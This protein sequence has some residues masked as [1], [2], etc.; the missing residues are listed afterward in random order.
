[1]RW[2]TV[3][4]LRVLL[5]LF[6]AA[7]AYAVTARPQLAIPHVAKGPAIDGTLTDEA[8]KSA[9]QIPLAWDL[10]HKAAPTQA[11]DVYVLSDDQALYVA[12][13]AK[14]T[15]EIV[16][17]QHT[18]DVGFD[19]DDEV[20]VDLWPGGPQGFRYLFTATPLGT[21]YQPSSANA[22]YAPKWQSVGKVRPGGFT[23]TRRSP[24]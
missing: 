8:W 12:F 6:A 18:D 2:F 22:A 1:M 4:V 24:V 19:T 11:T 20:Q 10:R 23:V 14:Q 9:K 17:N 16:A 3:P 13:D 21:H 7:P 15:A 5:A